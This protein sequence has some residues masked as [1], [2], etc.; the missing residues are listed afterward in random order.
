MSPPRG[1]GQGSVRSVGDPRYGAVDRHARRWARVRRLL[2]RGSV[3]GRKPYGG[4][5]RRV[6]SV[7]LAVV[8]SGTVAAC[9]GSTST[10]RPQTTTAVTTSAPVEASQIWSRRWIAEVESFVRSDKPGPPAPARIYSYT[11]G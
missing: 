1:R 11:S 3:R 6:R 4:L 10:S 8:V 9:G 2:T 7:W 5:V